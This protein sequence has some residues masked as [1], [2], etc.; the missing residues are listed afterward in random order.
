[1]HEF[2][3]NGDFKYAGSLVHFDSID[4]IATLRAI[5]S[6]KDETGTLIHDPSTLKFLQDDKGLFSLSACIGWELSLQQKFLTK[7]DEHEAN[8][9]NLLKRIEAIESQLNQQ[10]AA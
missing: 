4:D 2:D 10:T 1:M 6:T 9:A 3:M 5:K 8:I 7:H